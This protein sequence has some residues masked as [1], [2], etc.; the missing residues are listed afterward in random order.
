MLAPGMT[1]QS[2]PRD[3]VA[4]C[5][6]VGSREPGWALEDFE[7]VGI[8]P[9]DLVELYWQE[10]PMLMAAELERDP[11]RLETPKIKTLDEWILQTAFDPVWAG[12]G[13]GRDEI[14]RSILERAHEKYQAGERWTYVGHSLGSVHLLNLALDGLL[15]G[16]HDLI[17]LGSPGL[18]YLLARFG[19]GSHAWKMPEIPGVITVVGDPRD[20]IA[21]TWANRL[22][23]VEARKMRTKVVS[24]P[25]GLWG[26]VPGRLSG[27]IQAIRSH[28][29]YLKNREVQAMI[30]ETH[31]WGGLP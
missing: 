11:L 25:M 7:P 12:E 24:N 15:P 16:I 22:S 28:V 9:E 19:R 30:R 1:D 5:A 6:G 17:L 31:E 18:A 27:L 21:T 4:I 10:G 13:A 26:I 14:Y 20:R 8:P 23:G 2:I 29:S 3:R